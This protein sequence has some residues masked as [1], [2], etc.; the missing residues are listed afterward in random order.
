[1]YIELKWQ[2]L[3]FQ[4]KKKVLQSLILVN[5]LTTFSTNYDEEIELQKTNLLVPRKFH[6]TIARTKI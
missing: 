5:N 3:K 2:M 4:C 6:I 1:M